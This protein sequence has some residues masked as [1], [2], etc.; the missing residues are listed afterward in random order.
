MKK[1]TQEYLDHLNQIDQAQGEFDENKNQQ[2]A[3]K[4]SNLKNNYFKDPHEVFTSRHIAKKLDESE[5]EDPILKIEYE[6]GH[7]NHRAK[8]LK[9]TPNKK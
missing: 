7:Y 3:T 5:I 1:F 6:P 4:L 9:I 8:S 2:T